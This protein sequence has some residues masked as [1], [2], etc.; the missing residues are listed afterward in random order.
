MDQRQFDKLVERKH[1][2]LF[3][4]MHFGATDLNP[5]YG[6]SPD[7][8]IDSDGTTVGIEHTRYFIEHAGPAGL[9]PKAQET[10][11]NKII[12]K[13]W[14]LFKSVASQPLWVSVTFEDSTTYFANDVDAVAQTITSLV[15]SFLQ[16]PRIDGPWYKL[17]A[18]GFRRSGIP[19]PNG[20]AE[21]H[22]KKL[23][24]SRYEVWGPGR[25]YMVPH[26]EATGVQAVINAKNRRVSSYL[27]K[28]SV[29]W[30]LI[31][32]DDGSQASHFDVRPELLSHRFASQFTRV[33]LLRRFHTEL[34][35]L[36]VENV[37][38]TSSYQ[39]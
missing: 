8:L 13:A 28:C 21:I 29:A 18:W 26:L 27:R 17:A 19:W 37:P 2:Q 14:E 16:R 34:V 12:A 6:D 22:I 5:R 7:L 25:A 1:L 32:V 39:L 20:I 35:E 3:L 10:L 33:F 23:P 30:L 11:Q 4:E 36:Q 38:N 31:V 9:A 15:E 24:D